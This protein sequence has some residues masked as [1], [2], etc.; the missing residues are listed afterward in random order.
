MDFRL[1]IINLL[2]FCVIAIPSVFTIGHLIIIADQAESP[3][4]ANKRLG[5]AMMMAAF[6]FNALLWSGA[7]SPIG[8][9]LAITTLA[10]CAMG[11]YLMCRAYKKEN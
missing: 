7:L 3:K 2:V 5:F 9:G 4:K 11:M 6:I 1:M 10:F 8:V